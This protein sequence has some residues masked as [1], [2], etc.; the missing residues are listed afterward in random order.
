V[1]LTILVKSAQAQRNP[2]YIS[3]AVGME[4]LDSL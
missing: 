1:S 3:K 4:Q 2:E